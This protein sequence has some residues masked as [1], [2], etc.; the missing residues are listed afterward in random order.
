MQTRNVGTPPHQSDVVIE[1]TRAYAI[2]ASVQIGAI[3]ATALM[4]AAVAKDWAARPHE[5][6]GAVGETHAAAPP[7]GPERS[8]NL[9]VYPL[10]Y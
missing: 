3:V 9:A 6:V 4:T 10:L 5:A 1:S 8:G 7:P 2:R